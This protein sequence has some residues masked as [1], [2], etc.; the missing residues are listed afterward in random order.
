MTLSFYLSKLYLWQFYFTVI[1]CFISHTK[2]IIIMEIVYIHMH[3]CTHTC[4]HTC[5]HTF[6]KLA[7]ILCW[8][9]IG[10]SQNLYWSPI[11]TWD[12]TSLQGFQQGIRLHKVVMWKPK[13]GD[14]LIKGR[15]PRKSFLALFLYGSA[16]GTERNMLV[17]QIS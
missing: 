12:D 13:L 9:I 17:I 15:H 3:L 1:K 7:K 2:I 6:I 8:L 11:F 5:I 4:V 10:S 16:S 14:A